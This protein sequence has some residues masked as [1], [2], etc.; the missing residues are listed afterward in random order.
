M[1][2]GPA[3]PQRRPRSRARQVA[4][5][6][7]GVAVVGLVVLGLFYVGIAFLTRNFKFPQHQVD[8]GPTELTRGCVTTGAVHRSEIGKVDDFI[9]VRLQAERC[10][11][12]LRDALRV[13]SSTTPT[14]P[15]TSTGVPQSIGPR[16]RVD[17][18]APGFEDLTA[19]TPAE[20]VVT[21]ATPAVWSWQ[22]QPTQAGDFVFSLVVSV[23]DSRSNLVMYANDPLQIRVHVEPVA[24]KS[25]SL[26]RKAEDAGKAAYRFVLAGAGLVAA[27]VGAVLGV[28]Q[29][30]R[31]NEA[32][33]EKAARDEARYRE[34]YPQHA[35]RL[36]ARARS[37]RR[38][39]RS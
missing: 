17:L 1:Q 36:R 14:A 25:K 33:R 28:R 27:L 26:G 23:L 38:R 12:E 21:A 11:A 24:A 10:P 39:K 37:V 15:T 4:T 5:D 13:T 3:P 29:L 2:R 30:R 31:H 6:A 35:D 9:E 16:V 18:T 32:S 34:H 7:L 22:V 8:R 19:V 20:R